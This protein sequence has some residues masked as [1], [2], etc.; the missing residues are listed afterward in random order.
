MN[1][2]FSDRVQRMSGTA[3]REILKLTA[4]PEVIS[5]AGGLPASQCLPVQEIAQISQELL[6][7]PDATKILQ[8]GTTQGNY[9]FRESCVEYVKTFGIDNAA[10]EEILIVSG[11]QQGIDLACRTFLNKGDTV[12]VES[13]TYLAFLQIAAAYEV[14]IIGVNSVD[15]GIDTADL[16][17]KIKQYSPKLIYLVPTFSNP[18]GKTYP[19]EKR[20]QIAEITQKYNVIV[21]EDDPYSKLRF[22]GEEVPSIKSVGGDNIIFITSF[23][24]IVSPG[25][26]IGLAAGSAPIIQQM[27][28]CKQGADVHTSHLSQA[29]VHEFLKRGL[30]KRQIERVK[31][32]YKSKKELMEQALEKYMPQEFEFTR[33]EGGMFIW[34]EFK[35]DIDTRALFPKAIERKAAYVYGDVF[36]PQ[37]QGFNTLRLNFSNATPEQIDS[38]IKALGDMFKEEI[39]KN[40][41]IK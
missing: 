31:P 4:N 15:D 18:T 7:S 25:L 20:K 32:I 37:N 33:P 16:E 9:R 19:L 6:T 27:E 1:L 24:K 8:Y 28:K 11:G 3:T 2:N 30:I 41:K 17:D 40:K 10:P 34:G 5:F 26:R 35:A 38:G 21:I 23:S 14:N 12:L 13:P 29:I 22:A 36:Y 39:A